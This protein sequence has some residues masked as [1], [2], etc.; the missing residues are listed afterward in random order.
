MNI[1]IE[2]SERLKLLN[3]ILIEEKMDDINR[4]ASLAIS[5]PINY[6]KTGTSSIN[7]DNSQENKN[8]N[9]INAVAELNMLIAERDRIIIELTAIIDNEY[10]SE[11]IKRR[12]AKM[13]FIDGLNSK[14]IAAQVHCADGTVRN[15]I[16]EIK[17]DYTK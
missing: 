6:A 12:I 10:P 4:F 16:H 5:Q 17:I 11:H 13:Y 2:K 14:D 15:Y 3:R 1:V 7:A 8:I 9:Y